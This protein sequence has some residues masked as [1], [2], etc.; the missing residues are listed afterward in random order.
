MNK[1]TIQRY[2]STDQGTLGAVFVEDAR[3]S[4]SLELPDRDNQKTYSRIPPGIY[5]CVWRKSPRFGWTYYIK[6]VPG[7]S[8]ILCHAGN[9][10]GDR[11]KGLKTNTYGCILLGSRFGFIKNQLAVL[12]SRTAIRKFTQRLQREPF[13]LEVRDA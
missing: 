5:E 13:L 1:V 3:F 4:Y 7:R 11:K 2:P 6:D 8:W 10:A 12:L 9:L